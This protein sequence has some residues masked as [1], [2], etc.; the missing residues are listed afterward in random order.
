MKTVLEVNSSTMIY[1]RTPIQYALTN[2]GPLTDRK[3]NSIRPVVQILL[4]QGVDINAVSDR[5]LTSFHYA[6]MDEDAKAVEFLISE[7]ANVNQPVFIDKI[8][9][10]VKPSQIDGMT[11]LRF[12]EERRKRKAREERKKNG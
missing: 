1:D 5:G 6:I 8:D 12:L 4:N 9:Q 3:I 2:S 11:P 10:M 7:K